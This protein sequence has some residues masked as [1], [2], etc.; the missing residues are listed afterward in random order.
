MSDTAA[1]PSEV[2]THDPTLLEQVGEAARTH[3]LGAIGALVVL[4]FV[5]VAVLA[6][7]LAPYDVFTIRAE[8][9]LQAPSAAHWFGTDEFGRD[10]FSRI[11]IGSRTSLVVGFSAA[12]LGGTVGALLGLI[13]GFVGGKLDFTVQRG[14]DILLSFPMLVLALA[15]VAALGPSLVNVIFAIAVVVVPAAARVIRSNVLVI[16]ERPFVEAARGLGFSKARILFRHILPN[17]LA[18]FI[19]LVTAALGNAI[20]AEASLS[21]LG[22]GVPPPEPSWGAMLS[23]RSQGYMVQA[24]WMAIFPGLAVTVVVFGFN[25]LGDAMRDVLDPHS[26]RR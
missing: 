14:M 18:P 6:P 23:S 10:I 4:G 26:K 3:P 16:R 15:M 12:F 11:I 8:S 1:N 19:I 9:V 2:L 7:W 5:V 21:F 17:C 24:P 25:F 20:L 22:L 13:G